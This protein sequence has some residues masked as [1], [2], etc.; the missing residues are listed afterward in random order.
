MHAHFH[1][2]QLGLDPPAL[3]ILGNLL[4]VVAYVLII[5]AGFRDRAYG[6]PLVAICLNITWEAFFFFS[7]PTVPRCADPASVQCL[8][9]PPD[10]TGRIILTLWVALDSIILFQVLRFGRRWQNTEQLR[11]HFSGIVL[12]LLGMGL[13]WHRSFVTFYEDQNGIEDAW[14][15]NLLMS[16][17]FVVVLFL[18]PGAQALSLPAAWAKMLGSALNAAGLLAMEP[19]PFPGHSDPT[20]LYFLFASV[21]GFD[22]VYI[23]LLHRRRG[24]LAALKAAGRPLPGF[25]EEAQPA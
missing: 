6:V 22:M 25:P 1:A 5:R 13:L 9:S 17:L 12:V 7:C 8:C 3:L 2:L 21:F 11:R 20:M 24:E 4:W 16:M 23:V 10:A 18:R 19:F 14:I 15:I